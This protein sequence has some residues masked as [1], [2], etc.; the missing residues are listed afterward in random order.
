VICS[1]IAFRFVATFR[2]VGAKLLVKSLRDGALLRRELPGARTDVWMQLPSG[3]R[4]IADL[5]DV[6]QRLL[7]VVEDAAARTCPVR[8][9]RTAD[10]AMTDDVSKIDLFC[11]SDSFL[12]CAQTFRIVSRDGRSAGG[13]PRACS[14]I[15]FHSVR[16]PATSSGGVLI[17]N[18]NCDDVRSRPSSIWST[19]L[20]CASLSSRPCSLSAS[21]ISGIRC[22]PTPE[23][24][25]SAARIHTGDPL[26]ATMP[27]SSIAVACHP[28]REEIVWRL[29]LA[30][31]DAVDASH[32]LDRYRAAHLAPI[33]QLQSAESAKGAESAERPPSRVRRAA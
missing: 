20:N 29:R 4:G 24:S 12:S 17:V 13:S 19:L 25:A 31:V 28:P 2:F 26:K 32:L 16:N 6:A 15:A 8:F 7:I 30:T 21:A 33:R 23:R 11:R 22:R 1:S 14:R 18:A 9:A 10:T 27:S 5:T 3:I